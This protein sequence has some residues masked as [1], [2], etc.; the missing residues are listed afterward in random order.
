MHSIRPTPLTKEECETLKLGDII[1]IVLPQISEGALVFKAKV[2]DVKKKIV[3]AYHFGLD[4]K[5]RTYSLTLNFLRK[6]AY[7][8]TKGSALVSEYRPYLTKYDGTSNS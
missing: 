8:A 1:G 2:I 3:T 4:G 6:S 7:K 5:F